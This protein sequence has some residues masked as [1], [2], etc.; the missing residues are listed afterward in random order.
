MKTS[1][2]VR[3]T[4]VVA[5]CNLSVLAISGI[6][7]AASFTVFT[8]Q[9]AWEAA[10]GGK[11]FT[12]TFDDNVFEDFSVVST[13]GQVNNG[14][15]K[16]Q[17]NDAPLQ[18]TEWQFDKGI[19]AWGGEFWD[20][21]GPGGPGSGIKLTLGLLDGTT[22]TLGTEMTNSLSGDFFGIVSDELFDTVLLTEG[23]QSGWRETYNMDRMVYA[24]P[25]PT[26]VLGLLGLGA[27]GVGKALQRKK[28]QLS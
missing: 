28:Q 22:Q 21:A 2:L 13:V 9:T 16:D 8:D 10:V 25:E 27:F 14:L 11:F 23:T 12:E 7:N 3:L 1:R 26:S 4:L 6:A 5:S 17:I 18:T 24:V 19:T 20:L 15:W